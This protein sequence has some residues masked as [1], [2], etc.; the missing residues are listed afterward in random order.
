MDFFHC[1]VPTC[2]HDAFPTQRGCRKHVK[3]NYLWCYYF[4][5]QP[6]LSQTNSN[7]GDEQETTQ[8]MKNTK[9]SVACFDITCT[10]DKEFDKWLVGSGSGCKTQRQAQQVIRKSFKYLKFCFEDDEEE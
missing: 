5:E 10:L 3:K 4:D 7:S 6:D 2:N 8:I 1:P 9:K